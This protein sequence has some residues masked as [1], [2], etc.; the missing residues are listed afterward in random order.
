MVRL[1]KLQ[2]PITSYFFILLL[3]TG[4]GLLIFSFFS[5]EQ[6]NYFGSFRRIAAGL[7]LVGI[8]EWINH[9]KQ[10]SVQYRDKTNFIFQHV[11]HRKRNPSSLGNLMEISGLLLI[12]A[13]AAGY[14]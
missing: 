10:K 12:F 11:L 13:G 3:I 9:P 2:T 8:G 5:A 6:D 7:L 1:S 4:G 14:M